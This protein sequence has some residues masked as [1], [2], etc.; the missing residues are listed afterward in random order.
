LAKKK[1][2][3]SLD[4]KLINQAKIK[5]IEHNTTL[6][7]AVAALLASWLRDDVSIEALK[8]KLGLNK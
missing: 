4:E 1:L 5:A 3:L 6:S 8:E 2:T 7:D